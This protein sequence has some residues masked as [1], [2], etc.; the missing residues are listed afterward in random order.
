MFNLRHASLRNVVE[1]II[2]ALKARFRI[3]LGP[4]Y[5]DLETQNKVVRALC[6][7]HNF[8]IRSGGRPDEFTELPE[9][10]EGMD[11]DFFLPYN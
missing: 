1:R 3:L 4:M 11:T 9:Q 10:D 8:I 7:L 6:C 2:G 5:Y